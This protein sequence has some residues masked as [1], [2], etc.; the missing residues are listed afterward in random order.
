MEEFENIEKFKS[1]VEYEIKRL[2]S[3]IDQFYSQII[4]VQFYLYGSILS[5]LIFLSQ[6]INGIEQTNRD[7]FIITLLLIITVIAF[8][9]I[10][11]FPIILS[12]LIRKFLNKF[13][14]KTLLFPL[15]KNVSY[16]EVLKENIRD[17]E[18]Y[19]SKYIFPH[20]MVLILLHGFLGILILTPYYLDNTSIK[21]WDFAYNWVVYIVLTDIVTLIGVFT[22]HE[23]IDKLLFDRENLTSGMKLADFSKTSKIQIS[24]FLLI[25]LILIIWLILFPIFLYYLPFDFLIQNYAIFINVA[26]ENLFL[27]ILI[28][29]ITLIAISSSRELIGKKYKV[30]VLLLKQEKYREIRR[31]LYESKEADINALKKEFISNAPW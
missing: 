10:V 11:L 14:D 22:A 8:L 26:N 27:F 21:K 20:M 6:F 31:Q 18:L 4:P 24:F 13:K 3:V 19:R 23:S 17:R 2:D 29:V 15:I 28:F 16:S 5:V 7:N 9:Y 30:E 25:M 1:L 12:P